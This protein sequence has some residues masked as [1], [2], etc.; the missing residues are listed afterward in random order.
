M[1]THRAVEAVAGGVSAIVVRRKTGPARDLLDLGH[2][3]RDALGPDFPLLVNT[4]LDLALAIGA[5][6]VHLPE[7][8]VPV[9]AIR[10]QIGP[11][12]LVGV[13]CHSLES[14]RKAAEEG[15]DYVF[16]GPVYETPSK[17]AFG[18]PQGIGALTRVARESLV[19]VIGIGG[20]HG[21]N[22]ASLRLAGAS[23]VAIIGAL[24][25]SP[26]PR[27]QAFSLRGA[28]TRAVIS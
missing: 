9:S 18:A 28:W 2:L 7:A 11:D 19:P 27:A 4:R 3:L 6:G 12:G 22:L 14:V 10:E 17:A 26:D 5:Q 15:A 1:I 20:I 23:G 16:F 25:Y 24:A 8:H 21:E 13:S